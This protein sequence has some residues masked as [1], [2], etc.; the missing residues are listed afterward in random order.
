MEWKYM[1]GMGIALA[2]ALALG[3]AGCGGGGGGSDSPTAAVE[4]PGPTPEQQVAMLQ[5]QI[6]ALRKQLGLDADDDLGD[7]V[8]GLQAEAKRL[9]AEIDRRDEEKRMAAEEEE[10]DARNAMAK[11]LF[12]GLKSAALNPGTVTATSSSIAGDGTGFTATDLAFKKTDGTAMSAG[13]WRASDL[14]VTLAG[15]GGTHHARVYHN[16]D[17]P[18]PTPFEE[19]YTTDIVNGQFPESAM[20]DSLIEGADFVTGSGIKTHE[21]PEGAEWVSVRGKYHEAPGV[22]RCNTGN[23]CTSAIP[24]DRKGITLSSSWYFIPD[25]GA[26][27]RVENADYLAFGWWSHDTGAAV[28]VATFTDTVGAANAAVAGADMPVGGKAT[29]SGGAAG[30]Y[31]IYNPLSEDNHGGAYTATAMLEATF[32]GAATTLKGEL[33]GFMLEGQAPAEPWK[34]TLHESTIAGIGGTPSFGQNVVDGSPAEAMT[35]WSIGDTAS[36]K[37]GMWRAQMYNA[38]PATSDNAGTPNN[39]LGTFTS[40]F[41]NGVGEMVGAFGAS[42]S[43]N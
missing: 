35:T 3:L 9:Q 4:D 24:V 23:T 25:V 1:R 8:A 13:G 6:N 14:A 36:D 10:R 21:V 32:G 7:S 43:K 16:Q 20:T 17:D 34:V 22:Y 11:K 39:I 12:D 18:T 40:Q 28:S 5:A 29:Y 19:V 42:R 30:K 38:A 33:A 41:G 31:A 27:V 15:T 37:S 2:A 26:M